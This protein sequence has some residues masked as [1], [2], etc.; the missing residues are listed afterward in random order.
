V[1]PM[2]FLHDNSA[3]I[4][5]LKAS[6]FVFYSEK[7]STS[8]RDLDSHLWPHTKS[9]RKSRF[10]N[11]PELTVL[12][13]RT[14]TALFLKSIFALS[15]LGGQTARSTQRYRDPGPRCECRKNYFR[16]RT[17][18]VL[19]TDGISSVMTV[20]EAKKKLDEFWIGRKRRHIA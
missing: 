12:R 3:D 6:R 10:P 18:F 13:T 11:F 7:A 15:L 16:L 19:R 17:M 5:P 1:N 14:P 20:C 4:T 2:F 8:S 9:R